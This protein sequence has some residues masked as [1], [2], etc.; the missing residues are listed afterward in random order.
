MERALGHVPG[1]KEGGVTGYGVRRLGTRAALD[2]PGPG[3]C[4]PDSGWVSDAK[5]GN[6][7]ILIRPATAQTCKGRSDENR[8]ITHTQREFGHIWRQMQF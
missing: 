1:R 4:L 5:A 7:G 3:R 2:H 8:K 6:K